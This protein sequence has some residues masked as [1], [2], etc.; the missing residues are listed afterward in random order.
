MDP[1]HDEEVFKKVG[2]WLRSYKVNEFFD[3]NGKLSDE[4][5]SNC[6]PPELQM[7]RNKHTLP[8][9]K[10]LGRKN[11]RAFPNFSRPTTN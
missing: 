2:D 11:L 6:P 10:P 9:L 5:L 1:Q 8:A 4:I 3:K 7:S